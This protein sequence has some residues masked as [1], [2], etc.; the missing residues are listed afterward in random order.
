MNWL[1]FKDKFHPS[2]HK[3]MQVFIE[4]NEC[5]EIYKFL[6]EET[7]GGKLI[8]PSSHNV[9]RAF[10]ETS[11]DE[12]KCVI[13]G[14]NPYNKFVDDSPIAS[15][16]LFGA[17]TRKQDDLQEFYNGIEKELYD[18]LYLN[19]INGYELDHLTCQGILLINSSLTIEKDSEKGHSKIWKP[20]MEFLLKEVISVSAV[21]I[22]FL[23]KS[24]QYMPLVKESNHCYSLE[25]PIFGNM[26]NTNEVFSKINK[27]IWDSNKETIAWLN[28][29]A[30]F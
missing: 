27:N 3:Y 30:P 25:L 19:Y 21:P 9:Y 18:G 1:K 6:K 16:M 2:W 17:N 26:W 10:F 8:A 29:E 23:G 12:L 20:F 7:T 5:N 11:L 4:S 15:G 14:E 28:S 13:I 22:L 24:K